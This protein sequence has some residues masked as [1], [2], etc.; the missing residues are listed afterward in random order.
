MT[1]NQVFYLLA[2]IFGVAS[3]YLFRKKPT[4][5]K[6]GVAPPVSKYR[7]AGLLAIVLAALSLTLAILINS[8][9]TT[10]PETEDTTTPT[11][12][13]GRFP[14]PP[15]IAAKDGKSAPD[16]RALAARQREL[17]A[18]LV[19][20]DAQLDAHPDDIIALGDRGA[21][22]AEKKSWALAEK[23]FSAALK[24]KPKLAKASFD[25]AEMEFQQKRYD[26]AR[27]GFLALEY[28]PN[29]GNLAIYKVFLC[30]LFAGH[31]ALAKKELDDINEAEA[32]AAYYYANVA[33]FAYHHQAD[34]A[35]KWLTPA[36]YIFSIS[37]SML[38]TS[39]LN[40]L[41]YLPLPD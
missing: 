29:L 19:D 25:L 1:I 33:W 35:R 2:A 22:Y 4:K 20:L 13:G 21:V 16:I 27:P 30:D 10:L 26:N 11:P 32:D 14:L 37:K 5:R 3:I 18:R 36:T 28:D 31:E 23:D 34:Q 17:D 9:A 38:Y 40:D 15:P 8:T 24:L 7:P 12:E 6:R 41:G 39:S